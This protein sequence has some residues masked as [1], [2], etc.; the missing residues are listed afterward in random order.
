LDKVW[1]WQSSA[2]EVNVLGASY[3]GALMRNK[4]DLR[5]REGFAALQRREL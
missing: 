2:F 5:Q 4:G 1:R 3:N